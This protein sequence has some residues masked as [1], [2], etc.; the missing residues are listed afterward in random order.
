M[1]VHICAAADLHVPGVALIHALICTE[2]AC[3][4]S[5]HEALLQ[6]SIVGWFDVQLY[7]VHVLGFVCPPACMNLP[8]ELYPS[9][10]SQRDW[11]LDV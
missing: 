8:A 6:A 2:N 10:S 1:S 3:V 4:A 7:L 11:A 9:A 5:K